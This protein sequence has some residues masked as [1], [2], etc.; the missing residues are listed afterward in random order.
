MNSIYRSNR[1]LSAKAKRAIGQPAPGDKGSRKLQQLILFFSSETTYFEPIRANTGKRQAA[2]K[3]PTAQQLFQQQQELIWRQERLREQRLF[4]YSLPSKRIHL[5]LHKATYSLKNQ[6]RELQPQR[7]M[8]IPIIAPLPS[9]SS[10]I[11]N[12]A[13]VQEVTCVPY[14][15]VGKPVTRENQSH[16]GAIGLPP[17]KKSTL[18]LP[19]QT[20]NFLDPGIPENMATI[21]FLSSDSNQRW[22]EIGSCSL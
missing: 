7:Q 8:P 18:P 9:N 14:R 15:S 13:L 6:R 16:S 5:K 2:D 17:P 19:K 10:W 4:L 1:V 3:I 20:T 12:L 21:S 22:R 11:L